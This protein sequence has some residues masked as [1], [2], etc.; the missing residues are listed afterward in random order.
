MTHTKD[1]A[2]KL[3]LEALSTA[4]LVVED[5]M[6]ADEIHQA[7]QACEQA[8]A[9]Q[10]QEPLGIKGYAMAL[11]EV[12]LKLRDRYKNDLLSTPLWT[13]F[14]KARNKFASSVAAPP[15]AQ[16]AVPEKG[17]TP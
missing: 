14:E 12:A 6:L 17:N 4:H 3:A 5:D 13:E 16:P 1:E 15:E 10:V 2:L 8:L 7:A 11:N 9:A